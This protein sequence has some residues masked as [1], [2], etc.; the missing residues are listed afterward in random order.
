[1]SFGSKLRE[2]ERND[3]KRVSSPSYGSTEVPKATAKAGDESNEKQRHTRANDPK[4]NPSPT[5]TRG[6]RKQQ[7]TDY[8]RSESP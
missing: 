1:M 4:L 2:R 6:I 8:E 7:S 5:W 3:P